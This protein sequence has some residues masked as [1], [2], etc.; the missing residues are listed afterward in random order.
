MGFSLRRPSAGSKQTREA[1]AL[2]GSGP[3]NLENSAVATG[4]EKVSFHSNPNERQCQ[5]MIKLLHN[6][7][8]VRRPTPTPC[9]LH[10]KGP[11]PPSLPLESLRGLRDLT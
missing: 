1:R 6:C 11:G 2:P 7:S 8:P 9:C 10:A 4:L 3:A 5:R